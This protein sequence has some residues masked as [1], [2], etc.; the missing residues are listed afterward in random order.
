MFR[1]ILILTTVLMVHAAALAEDRP[2]AGV[3]FDL[4][5][6][7]NPPETFPV[8]REEL[9][10]D[11]VDALFYAGVSYHGRPT[12][13]FAYRGFP[14]P[15]PAHPDRKVPGMVLI[16]GGGGTAFDRWVKVWTD[17]GYAAIAMDLCGCVPVGTYGNWQRHDHGGPPGWDASFG[18]LEEPVHDQWTWHAV[19]AAALGHSL[20]RN[21]P[22]VDPDRIGLTGISWGGYLTCIVAGV[23]DRFQFAAPVYGC[24]YLGEDS[25]WLPAFEKLGPEKASLWLRQWDPSGYLA[26]AK[27]PLLWVNGTNDF[28]YPPDSWQKSYRLPPGPRT[29]CLRIRMPH[30]HGPAGENPAEI[31]VMANHVLR[32]EPALPSITAQGTEG[33]FAWAAFTAAVPL[34]KAELCFTTDRGRWQDRNWESV[35]A[36]IHPA[37]GKVTATIPAEATVYYLNLFDGRDCAVSTEHVER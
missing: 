31:H 11:S 27:R 26:S 25:A 37:E 5:A 12:R 35:E 18:Q 10:A 21:D 19:S 24:G 34:T 33:E 4:A 29:L 2:E 32:G 1:T 8:D 36:M 17:R 15:D 23:D 7:S 6:L 13:V 3:A 9:R 28:A 30:G 22:R 20:L 16:H 14:T